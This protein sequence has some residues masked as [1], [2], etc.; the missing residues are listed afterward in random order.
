MMMFGSSRRRKDEP[1]NIDWNKYDAMLSYGAEHSTPPRF[2][3]SLAFPFLFTVLAPLALIWLA[4]SLPSFIGFYAL[5][6]AGIAFVFGM[7]WSALWTWNYC[8]R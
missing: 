2:T 5:C 4:F 6:A 3:Q 8:K 7:L 1:D